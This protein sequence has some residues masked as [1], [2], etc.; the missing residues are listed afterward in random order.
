MNFYA[1]LLN[2][3]QNRLALAIDLGLY[4]SCLPIGLLVARLFS[5]DANGTFLYDSAVPCASPSYEI[6]VIVLSILYLCYAFSFL[7]HMGQRIYLSTIYFREEDHETYL[8]IVEVEYMTHLSTEWMDANFWLFS[9]FKAHGT[10]FWLHSFL[11]KLG[12]LMIYSL[13]HHEVEGIQA[14]AFWVLQTFWVFYCGW[15]KPFRCIA[16]NNILMILTTTL[17]ALGVFAMLSG[18][19]VK[20][21]LVVSSQQ[22][23]V[24][25]TIGCFGAAVLLYYLLRVIFLGKDNIWPTRSTF[26]VLKAEDE[27]AQWFKAIQ[28]AKQVVRKL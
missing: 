4:F 2:Q 25:I 10:R 6:I 3:A 18:V 8:Q 23:I 26:K 5:C 12:L 17:W 11:Y 14:F 13:S 19:G 1:F 15:K 24:L 28:D 9:S 16:T 20:S 22:V 7:Y 21:A 27:V